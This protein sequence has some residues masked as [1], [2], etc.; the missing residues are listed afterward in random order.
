MHINANIHS[1]EFMWYWLKKNWKKILKK[2]GSG[3]PLL[4]RVVQSIG[5]V[6]DSSQEKEVRGFFK[7]NPVH[8]TEMTLEQT[9]ERV[10]VRS[11]FLGRLKKEFR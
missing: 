10:R 9:L 8:G 4:K 2:A 11:K 1:K 7:K 6:I 5:H 3:N